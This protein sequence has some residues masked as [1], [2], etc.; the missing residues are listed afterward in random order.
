[1]YM[2]VSSGTA[3]VI[4]I[5]EVLTVIL[6]YRTEPSD[7]ASLGFSQSFMENSAIVPHPALEL[8]KPS[9]Y[10]PLNTIV[11]QP[12]NRPFG[13]NTTIELKNTTSTSDN[14]GTL[15]S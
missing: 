3:L 7:N 13:V 5:R 15:I 1:M 4:C 10:R 14:T 8:P 6:G 11:A 2:Q 12:T 9:I